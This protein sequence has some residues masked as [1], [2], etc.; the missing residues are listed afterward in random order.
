MKYIALSAFNYM[1]KS[2]M[3]LRNTER[4]LKVEDFSRCSLVMADF[5]VLPNNV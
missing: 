1:S 4:Y 3:Q 5:H 2:R